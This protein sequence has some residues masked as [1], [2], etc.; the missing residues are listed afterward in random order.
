[1]IMPRCPKCKSTKFVGYV[2]ELVEVSTKI[3]NGEAIE[4]FC[5]SSLPQRKAAF[6]K[7]NCGHSWQFKNKW[8]I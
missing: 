7:C 6:G 5:E 4:S 1:M 8:A 3:V 2:H